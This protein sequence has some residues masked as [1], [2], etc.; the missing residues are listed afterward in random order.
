[1]HLL[2]NR[3]CQQPKSPSE[4]IPSNCRNYGNFEEK[5]KYID[6]F[7][8]QLSQLWQFWKRYSWLLMTAIVATEAIVEKTNMNPGDNICRN[9]GKS[10]KSWWQQLLQ[11]WQF[12]RKKIIDPFWA[13]FM[14]LWQF[15]KR[16]SWLLMT[17][18]VAI[19]EKKTYMN[20]SW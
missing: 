16:Y 10:E 2:E 8:S 15:W 3:T 4:R 14:Q 20:T 13:Q 7:S 1:M 11:L 17:T 19:V 18:I 9:Y 6:P 12:W 5:K